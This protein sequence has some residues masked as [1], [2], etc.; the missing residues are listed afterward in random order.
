[1][2]DAF[3]FDE[4]SEDIAEFWTFGG[5]GSTGT[6]IMT[7]LGVAAM[8]ISLIGFVWLEQKKL[9]R[10]TEML[11]ASGALER[12]AVVVTTT[13]TTIITSD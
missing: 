1:M 13:T 5:E 9:R 11:R 6:Y 8:L 2:F 3:P 12:P 10:Q 4:W 7:A